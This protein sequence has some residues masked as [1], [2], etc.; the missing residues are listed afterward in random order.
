MLDLE[1]YEIFQIVNL[2]AFILGLTF[3]AIAQKNQFCFSGSIKDYILTDSTKRAAS[4][5]MA[6]IVAII[7]TYFVINI[8][9]IDLSEAI[10]LKENVN[11]VSLM[12]LEMNSII[13]LIVQEI[14]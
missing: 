12:K 10:Y 8:N 4:V 11:Y 5:V 2:S 6:I 1:N 7:S 3:G 13:F 9:E 14:K